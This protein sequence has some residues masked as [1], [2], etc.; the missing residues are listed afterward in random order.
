MWTKEKQRESNRKYRLDH[1]DKVRESARKYY[2]KNRGGI[3]ARLKT[4]GQKKKHQNYYAR[5]RD[6]LLANG[7]NYYES[8]REE[9]LAYAKVYSNTIISHNGKVILRKVDKPPKPLLC[10]LCKRK[11][12]LVYHHWEDDQPEVGLW[13]CNPCHMAI[14]RMIKVGLLLPKVE[15]QEK[16][17]ASIKH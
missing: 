12:Y 10:L 16:I 7:L 17:L 8:H 3:L 14:H 2:L 15:S 1:P 9:R 4:P 11:S 6:K 13:I 5:N